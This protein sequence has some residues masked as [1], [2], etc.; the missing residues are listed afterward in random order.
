MEQNPYESPASASERAPR[1]FPWLLVLNCLVIVSIL[2]MVLAL[3]LPDVDR[4][5]EAYRQQQRQLKE[6]ATAE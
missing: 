6:Q 1:G 4:P 2:G 5:S 3:F